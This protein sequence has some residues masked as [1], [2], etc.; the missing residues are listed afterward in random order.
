MNQI[1]PGNAPPPPSQPSMSKPTKRRTG[2]R[3]WLWW[4]KLLLTLLLG[5]MLFNIIV[6]MPQDA[7]LLK[8]LD[9][10]P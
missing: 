7:P 3:D 6:T 4:A 8:L 10:L 5:L 9:Y 2:K 1:M